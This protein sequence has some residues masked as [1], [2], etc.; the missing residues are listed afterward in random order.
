[1]ADWLGWLATAVFVTSYFT[2][3]SATLRRIQ[4]LAACLWLVYG[5]LIHPLPVVVANFIVAGVAIASS[6]QRR[7]EAA[8]VV[9]AR[10]R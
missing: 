3:R 2:K 8:T 9:R 5:V 7:R 10:D 4:G 1:M 6:F